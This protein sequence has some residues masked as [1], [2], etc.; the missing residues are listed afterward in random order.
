LLGGTPT[1]PNIAFTFEVIDFYYH[2]RRRQPA[3]AIQSFAKSLCATHS[4][5]NLSR[6][7][8]AYVAMQEHLDKKLNQVLERGPEWRVK[9]SC[10]CCGFEQEDKPP[11]IPARMHAM[12]GNNSQKHLLSVGKNEPRTFQSHYFIDPTDVNQFANEV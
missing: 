10:P 3:N 8:D 6:T 4:V 11:L 12:D 1:A 7:F 9:Y 2:L 5:N